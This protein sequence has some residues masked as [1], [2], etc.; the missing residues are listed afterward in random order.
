M[1]N[2]F[3]ASQSVSIL[4][5]GLDNAG[6]STILSHLTHDNDKVILPTPGMK[7]AAF[8]KF[9]THWKV[10]D[11]SGTGPNRKLWPSFY[12][13]VTGIVFV[14]DA[15]D[16]ERVSNAKEELDLIINAPDFRKRKI[17]LLVLFNKTDKEGCASVNELETVLRLPQLKATHRHVDVHVRGCSGI[18]GSGIEEGFRWLADSV[19][20]S[21]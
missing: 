15:S 6:K 14:V 5:V 17:S 12:Q 21:S 3:T 8:S 9:H 7:L 13:H 11:C 10:W 2:L 16:R 4:C 1:G 18:K 19:S 20:T